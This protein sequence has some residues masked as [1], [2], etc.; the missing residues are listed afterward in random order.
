MHTDPLNEYAS[1]MQD[2]KASDLLLD[3][4]LR[5]ADAERQATR[6]NARATSRATSSRKAQVHPRARHTKGRAGVFALAACLAV[7]AGIVGVTLL[8]PAL[9]GPSKTLVGTGGDSPFVVKAYG[10]VDDTLLPTG[11]QGT[12]FFNCET[13]TQRL[14]PYETDDYA[15]EGFYTG[16]VFNVESPDKE[17][18]R[19]QANVSK[20]ELYRVTSKVYSRESDPEFA[21]EA[22]LWKSTKIGQ[23]EY[24][25]KYDYVA[26]VLF[27]GA[28]NEDDENA[29]KDRNDPSHTAKVNLY[30]RLGATIDTDVISTPE[31]SMES[32]SFGLWT[33]ESFDME[34]PDPNSDYDSEKKLNAALDTLNGAQLTVTVTF[35]DGTQATQVID[36]HAADFKANVITVAN[37]MNK[38]LELVPEIVEA[39]NYE[40]GTARVADENN[41]IAYIHTLYGLVNATNEDP[42]PCGEATHPYLETPLTQ[43]RQLDPP[44]EPTAEERANASALPPGP[45]IPKANLT[46]WGTSYDDGNGTV[47]TFDRIERLDALPEGL[48]IADLI[49]YYHGSGGEYNADT[50]MIETGRGYSIAAD[51]TLSPGFSYVMLTKTITNTS[52][53]ERDIFLTEGDFVTLEEDG[54]GYHSSLAFIDGALWRSDHDGEPWDS[55]IYFQMMSPGQTQEFSLLYVLPDEALTSNLAYAYTG[56]GGQPEGKAIHIGSLL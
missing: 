54:D 25:N 21:E 32:Y 40:T 37:G 10:S 42:F 30:Q 29:N 33:N 41:G 56:L 5:R 18:V 49:K 35:T 22:N 47:T 4:V 12:L 34:N 17:I 44:P 28:I 48:E 2:V 51:G 46:D 23:G 15:N 24:L 27:Y 14:I 7:L 16:C 20:G 36:L 3:S 9:S 39:P 13:E 6:A 52:N 26:H 55:H 53:E 8:A 1:N 11:S 50:N 31:E 45:Y 43:P 38:V 19:I